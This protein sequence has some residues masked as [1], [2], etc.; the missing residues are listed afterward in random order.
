[1]LPKPKDPMGY[2]DKELRS[3]CRGE[4]I[5]F[6]IFNKAFGI[7]T[8]GIAKNG[9]SRYYVCDVERALYKLGNKNGKFHEWD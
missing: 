4:K 7:N 5:L 2:T 1:M 3:I 6:R 8:C 9:T